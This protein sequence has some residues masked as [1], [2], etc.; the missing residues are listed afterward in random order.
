MGEH[1]LLSLRLAFL[2]PNRST[3]ALLV[4][5]VAPM[6]GQDASV[7]E[8]VDRIREGGGVGGFA[9]AHIADDRGPFEG[10][11]D[12]IVELRPGDDGL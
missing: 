3:S 8:Q 9:T 6:F 11:R 4:W 1:P 10:L 12:S 2:L 5:D 7:Q